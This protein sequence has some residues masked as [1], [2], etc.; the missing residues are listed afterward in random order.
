MVGEERQPQR[1]SVTPALASPATQEEPDQLPIEILNASLCY[2][3]IF[4]YVDVFVA[5]AMLGEGVPASIA[6]PAQAVVPV[7]DDQLSMQNA[8]LR[9]VKLLGIQHL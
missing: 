8:N 2:D 3:E 6:A 5:A 4:C 9:G 1:P 7:R